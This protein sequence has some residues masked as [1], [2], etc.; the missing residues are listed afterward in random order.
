MVD[1]PDERGSGDAGSG[2]DAGAGHEHALFRDV[3]VSVVVGVVLTVA[4][5]ALA[6]W[7]GADVSITGLESFAVFTSYACTYLA[8]RQRRVNYVVGMTSTIAYAV[9]FHR[10]GLVA[11]AVLNVYLTPTLVYGWF[12]WHRDARTR[13]V[14]NVTWRALP[15]YAAVTAVAY[16]GALVVINALDGQLAAWDAV[17]LVGSVFAQFLLD[18][19][20]LQTWMVWAVVNVIAIYVYATTGL[21]L[22]AAQYVCFLLNTVYGHFSWRATMTGTTFEEPQR[23]A[24][25]QQASARHPTQSEVR[26]RSDAGVRL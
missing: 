8:V 4:S 22:A 10:Q 17:I 20:K 12:R 6:A 26:A 5:T 15:A 14:T 24:D 16:V 18:N 9:L 23:S 1:G 3:V 2:R 13:P 21:A 7:L 11:S 19:K 25:P